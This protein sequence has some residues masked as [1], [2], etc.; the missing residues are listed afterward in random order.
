M[1][2]IYEG[3]LFSILQQEMLSGYF[4]SG[5]AVLE[6]YQRVVDL[7]PDYPYLIDPLPTPVEEPATPESG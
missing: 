7:I 3:L 5:E 1:S 2:E 6:A 4:T